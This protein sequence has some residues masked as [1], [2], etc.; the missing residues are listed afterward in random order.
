[1]YTITFIRFINGKHRNINRKA[2]GPF[3][4]TFSTIEELAKFV[5]NSTPKLYMLDFIDNTT[6]HERKV[7]M[8]KYRALLKKKE[9]NHTGM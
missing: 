8:S 6:R 2:K 4:K 3:K 9:N 1:M 5:V 7:F